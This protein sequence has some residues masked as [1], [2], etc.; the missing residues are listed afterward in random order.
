MNVTIANYTSVFLHGRNMIRATLYDPEGKP[1]LTGV[2]P[3]LLMT[4][5]QHG[6]VLTNPAEVLDT[7]VMKF[8]HGA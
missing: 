2:L 8:G 4:V 3:T 5:K 7:V 6:Y 1:L